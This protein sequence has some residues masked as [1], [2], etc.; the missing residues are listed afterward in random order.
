MTE[1]M[2]PNKHD[3]KN[4][5]KNDLKETSTLDR[6]TPLTAA[7][8]TLRHDEAE[9]RFVLA[10]P[11]YECLLEY[12]REGDGVNFIHTYVPFRLRG[13]GLG[14]PLVAAG[15]AWAVEAGLRIEAECWFVKK[16]MDEHP[17]AVPAA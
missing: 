12:E 2:T 5:S 10:V 13:K 16:Y 9:Q 15:L 3:S 17:D 11:P 14:Q 6:R 1:S 4:D 8:Y 7:D